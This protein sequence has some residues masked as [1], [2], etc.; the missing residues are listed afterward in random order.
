MDYKQ[1]N[2]HSGIYKII[3]EI[4]DK[5]Y[6]GSSVNLR[7]RINRHLNDLL[8]NRHPSS[9][10]QNAFN[11]YGRNSFHVII[12][13]E[14]NKDKISKKEL[15]E[16]E[17]IYLD[18]LKPFL[19][20][21]GYNTCS[22]ASSPNTGR[23]SSETKNKISKSMKGHLVSEE[24]KRKIGEGNKNKKMSKEAIEKIR[25][26]KIGLKQTDENVNKRAK[27]YSFI[28]P[29]GKIYKGKNLKRF[30]EKHH[31]HRSNLNMVLSGKRKSH[32]GFKKYDE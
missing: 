25:I 24:T 10:L 2:T 4:N 9:Y 27:D 1:L 16:I 6:I 28:G 31:L 7:K 23:L 8:N 17:Q 14:F 12:V 15:L 3:C 21:I 22:I 19:R 26:S 30:A 29:D 13:E 18:K 5:F 32:H 11:K 20:E